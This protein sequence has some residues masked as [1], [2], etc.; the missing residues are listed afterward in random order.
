[1]GIDGQSWSAIPVDKSGRALH[2]TP[3]WMDTRSAD[4]ARET[5]ERVGFDRIF[6][7][8]GNPLEPTYSTA[9]MLW[10]KKHMPNIYGNTHLFLQSNSYIALKLTGRFTQ[11][12]SQGY[13]VHA[14]DMQH[15]AVG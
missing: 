10:F 1:M 7:V 6:S 2:N 14:F 15:R 5:T 13:G 3:I 11:D 4:I 9:K 12:L 8:S